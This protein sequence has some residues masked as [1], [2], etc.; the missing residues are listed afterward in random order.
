MIDEKGRSDLSAGMDINP[1]QG[2]SMLGPEPGDE[3][4]LFD[5]EFMRKAISGRRE[6]VRVGD[7]NLVG[8]GRG[9]IATKTGRDV[10]LEE[11]ADAG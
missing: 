1:S 7:N 6:D 9:R 3:R 5:E 4:H 10:L 8:A 11:F 2:M